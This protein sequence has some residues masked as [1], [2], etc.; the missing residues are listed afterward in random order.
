MFEDGS[1]ARRSINR[2]P[3]LEGGHLMAFVLM[4]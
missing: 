4:M 1:L 3:A 2:R